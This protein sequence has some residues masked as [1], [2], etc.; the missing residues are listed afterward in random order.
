MSDSHYVEKGAQVLS[1]KRRWRRRGG[2]CVASPEL[3]RSIGTMDTYHD[4]DPSD[5]DFRLRNM[6]YGSTNSRVAKIRREAQT[7]GPEDTLSISA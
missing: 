7:S 6:T 4:A 2:S 5:V 3:V 1:I